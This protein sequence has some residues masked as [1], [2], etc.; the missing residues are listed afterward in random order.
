[1]PPSQVSNTVRQIS[2]V[3]L[4]RSEALT[5]LGGIEAGVQLAER[6]K[7][8]PDWQNIESIIHKLISEFPEDS[9]ISYFAYILKGKPRV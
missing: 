7:L 3:S 2:S 4:T 8:I 1:M 9:E 5:I 6:D